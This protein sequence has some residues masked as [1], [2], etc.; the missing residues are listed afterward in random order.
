M[1]NGNR[2]Q[3]TEQAQKHINKNAKMITTKFG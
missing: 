1:L 3:V 2:T